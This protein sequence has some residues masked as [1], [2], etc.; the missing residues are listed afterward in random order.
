MKKYL[1]IL[2]FICL[3]FN[4]IAQETQSASVPDFVTDRPDATESP[5]VVPVGSLQVETGAFTTSFEENGVKEEVFGYHTT[6]LRYGILKNLELRG[7]WNFEERQSTVNGN[8]LE[9]VQNGLSPLLFG[10][11]IAI[12]QEKGWFPEM[13]LVGHIFLPFTA[14][15]DFKSE[16]TAADFRFAFNRTLSERSGIAYNLG[17]RLGGDSAEFAYISHSLTGFQLQGS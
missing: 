3:I 15:S 5:T 4:I 6:L 13:G 14:S 8:T 7:G 12:A 11:K 1:I 9:N 16:F 10:A 17:G 2:C